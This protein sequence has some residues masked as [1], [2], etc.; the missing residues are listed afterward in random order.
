[1][2]S[3]AL[4]DASLGSGVEA[5]FPRMFSCPVCDRLSSDK[6]TVD[7]FSAYTV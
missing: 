6:D 5:I 1:M 3:H 4:N 7:S 2:R